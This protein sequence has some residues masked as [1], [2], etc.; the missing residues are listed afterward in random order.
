MNAK[1]WASYPF[2]A[3]MVLILGLLL[4][5]SQ[6]HAEDKYWIGGTG[7]WDDPANWNPY[8]VP[9]SRWDNLSLSDNVFLTNA[10]NSSATAYF[11]RAPYFNNNPYIGSLQVYGTGAGTMG[12]SISA[13]DL[14]AERG[15]EIG[16]NGI[17]N[18]TGGKFLSLD[19]MVVRAGGTYNLQAGS[20]GMGA[21]P[22]FLIYGVFN[23]SG[24]TVGWGIGHPLDQFYVG[25]GGVYNLSG[26]GTL[27]YYYGNSIVDAGGVFNQNGGTVTGPGQ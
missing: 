6:S 19:R 2:F 21:T 3:M 5:F 8:G 7:S 12:L 16:Y 27:S 26:T 10:P 15:S 14:Y 18:Q 13:G 4:T 9:L 25:Q 20:L 11:S 23:Q 22:T 1:K 17:I 24:G